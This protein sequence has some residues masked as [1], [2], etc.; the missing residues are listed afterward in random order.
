MPEAEHNDLQ[1]DACIKQCYTHNFQLHQG[2]VSSV[3][4]K[5]SHRFN[6]GTQT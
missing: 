3:L 1:L 5:I 2:K 6:S 4:M